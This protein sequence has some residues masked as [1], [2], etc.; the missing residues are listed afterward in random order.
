MKLCKYLEHSTPCCKVCHLVQCVTHVHKKKSLMAELLEQV[1]QWHKMYCHDLEG[2][3]SKPGQVELG[4][5][6]TSV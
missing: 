3:G 4:V 5:R 1:S 6:S 2:M